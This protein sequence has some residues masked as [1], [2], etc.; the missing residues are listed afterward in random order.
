[1]KTLLSSRQFHLAPTPLLE[2]K[3]NF[4]FC[5]DEKA[6]EKESV[7][8]EAWKKF[9]EDY[10]DIAG[11]SFERYVHFRD[12]SNLEWVEYNPELYKGAYGVDFAFI[13]TETKK[14]YDELGPKYD[15]VMFVIDE[16]NW[17]TP[18]SAW[19]WNLGLFYN[20]HQVQLIRASTVDFTYMGFAMEVLHAMDN[21]AR[22]ELGVNVETIFGVRN[23]DEDIVH[24]KAYNYRPYIAQ[25]GGLLLEAFLKRNQRYEE[26]LR[27]QSEKPK[28]FFS[29]YLHY[30]MRKDGEVKI[31]QDCL[32]WLGLFPKDMPSTGN[33][34]DIT[35]RAVL[36]FWKQYNLATWWE[37]TTLGGRVV[38]PKTRSKLNELFN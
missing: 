17:K 21:F 29:R 33:Y 30:G 35:A 1:M 13:N 16:A 24:A 15:C 25:V 10:R 34:L 37:Q 28:R 6:R 3:I 9:M 20:G 4:Y 12:L 5:I 11:L 18:N 2:A 14:I 7:I 36:A 19:G 22:T 27:K 38:G 23:F 31:L 26:W 32:K 8:W